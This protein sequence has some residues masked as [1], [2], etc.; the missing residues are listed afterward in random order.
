MIPSFGANLSLLRMVQ[1]LYSSSCCSFRQKWRAV[2][3]WGTHVAVDKVCPQNSYSGVISSKYLVGHM[4]PGSLKGLQY[5]YCFRNFISVFLRSHR[6]EC[7]LICPWNPV[8]QPDVQAQYYIKGTS[9]LTI[10]MVQELTTSN[11][12]YRAW[13]PMIPCCFFQVLWKA[14]MVGV[15]SSKSS[16]FCNQQ[17]SK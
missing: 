14:A 2:S 8:V 7:F 1:S 15:M 12:I 13:F 10:R 11:V 9:Q 6:G 17:Y 3:L 16:L 5:F 4:D